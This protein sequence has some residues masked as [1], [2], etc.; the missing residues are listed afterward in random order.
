[1]GI[2]RNLRK[3]LTSAASRLEFVVRCHRLEAA[4]I[5]QAGATNVMI[6]ST[7]SRL[8]LARPFIAVGSMWS[9]KGC[10]GRLPPREGH[11]ARANLALPRAGTVL[12]LRLT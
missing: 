3:C 4:V 6:W 8:D 9:Q 2:E 11:A 5:I 7:M 1:M 10:V 12:S